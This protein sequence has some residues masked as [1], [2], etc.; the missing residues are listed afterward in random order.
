MWARANL[1]LD[2]DS[3]QCTLS[4]SEVQWKLIISG[5]HGSIYPGFDLLISGRKFSCC[6]SKLS[7]QSCTMSSI[8]LIIL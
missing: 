7:W 1:Y 6:R 4:R 2:K 5:L 3:T 8:I